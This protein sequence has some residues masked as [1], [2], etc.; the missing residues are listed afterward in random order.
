MKEPASSVQKKNILL[1]V[2]E[3]NFAAIIENFKNCHK[4]IRVFSPTHLFTRKQTKIT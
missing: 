2:F 3:R 1:N 4:I